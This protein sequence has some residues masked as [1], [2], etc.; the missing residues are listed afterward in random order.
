MTRLMLILAALACSTAFSEMPNSDTATVHAVMFEWAFDKEGNIR[1][2]QV[3]AGYPTL[4]ACQ[5]AMRTV[6]GRALVVEEGLTPQLLCQAVKTA[7]AENG[8]AVTSMANG[9]A[10]RDLDPTAIVIPDPDE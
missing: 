3:I 2:A 1:H 5:N 10:V 9:P 7:P 6:M 4:D 8:R